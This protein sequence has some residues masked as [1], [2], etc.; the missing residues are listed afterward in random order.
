MQE[1]PAFRHPHDHE[2]PERLRIVPWPDSPPGRFSFPPSHPYLEYC[3]VPILGPTGCLLWRRLATMATA[4]SSGAEIE[5]AELAS[6][7]GVGAHGRRAILDR[8][9]RRICD[10]GLARFEDE[11]TLLV[12]TGLP[13][14]SPR[15]VR[16]LGTVPREA[17][18]RFTPQALRDSRDN[19]L[20]SAALSYAERGWPVLPLHPE[21]KA[22]DGKLVPRG[23]HDAT[24]DER[25]IRAWWEAS[26]R[27]NIGIRTGGGIDVLDVDGPR[28]LLSDISASPIVPGALVETG[29]GFHLYFA[30]GGLPSRAALLAG[31]DV[32]GAGGYVVAP[33]S[34]H[35]SG[36][37]YRFVDPRSGEQLIGP[38]PGP[39]PA[40]PPA[41]VELCRR[42]PNP[43]PAAEPVRIDASAYARVALEG[44]CSAVAS[45]PVGARNDRLNRAAFAAG[46][47]V[48]SGVLDG[49]QATEHLV[50]AALRAGLPE[51]EARR[52]ISSGLRAGSERPRDLSLAGER[53]E[54]SAAVAHPT[55]SASLSRVPHQRPGFQSGSPTAMRP[56]RRPRL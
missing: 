15:H 17:H 9:L 44:E 42:S 10:F 32:K 29:R 5:R 21:E 45:T 36:S 4:Q 14:L 43:L 6:D 16:G 7:M 19:P 27:A 13:L 53:A 47:L 56:T 49:A 52:T 12:K 48:G 3:W 20:L 41:L 35:P 24:C 2:A 37:Q 54:N 46:T 31:I 39:F 30:C 18:E 22:P 50:S 23:L 11:K 8:S 28:S 38:P 26:P 25:T 40:P 33:P 55:S 34:I 1:I 51:A